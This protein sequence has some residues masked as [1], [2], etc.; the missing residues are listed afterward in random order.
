MPWEVRNFI[1]ETHSIR[2]R[3]AHAGANPAPKEDTYRDLDTMQRLAQALGD[4]PLAERLGHAKRDLLLGSSAAKTPSK[5]HPVESAAGELR[6][7][8]GDAIAAQSDTPQPRQDPTPASEDSASDVDLALM[9]CVKTKLEGRHKAKDLFISPL[10]LGRRARAEALGVPWFILSAKYGLLDPER[11][12]DTYDVSLN[13]A[14][15]A[16]RR[17]WAARVLGQLQER[18]GSVAGKT[19]EVHAGASYR[20]FGLVQGLRAAGARVNVPLEHARQGE[21]LAW[22][23]NQAR[24]APYDVPPPS[25]NE[26][27]KVRHA[28]ASG[29]PASL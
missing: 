10:F 9:G 17:A 21:Q 23:T 14:S 4:S 12:V 24:Q 16:E 5:P 15:T 8:A 6:D 11:E 27:P 19:V 25:R 1:K 26:T 28:P 29:P 22:Y 7:S 18:F 3:W 2:N 20:K 13:D